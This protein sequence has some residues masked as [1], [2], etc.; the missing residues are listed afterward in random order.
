[1]TENDKKIVKYCL[2][3]IAGLFLVISFF[4]STKIIKPGHE[5]IVLVLGKARESSISEGL[6]FVFPWISSVKV[7][8]TQVKRTEVKGNE[9][10][11]KDLQ[12]VTSAMVVNYHISKEE[13][14]VLYRKI[15]MDFEDV[16]ISPGIQECFKA[17]TAEYTAESLITKRSE[18]SEKIKEL[19][20]GRLLTYGIIVDQVNVTNFEFSAEF[21]RAIEAKVVMEQDSLRAE[22]ELE[23]IKFEAMQKEEEAKGLAAAIL[24]QAKA[25][26]ESLELRAKAATPYVIALDAIQQWDGKLPVTITFLGDKS[27][28][29]PIFNIKE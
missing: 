13:V 6:N 3:F 29:V 11:S 19:L 17:I 5:G 8:S 22:K 14:V 16:V 2:Y 12:V 15:G 10:S 28:L 20:S 9:A 23:K 27:D 25:E 4:M 24:E 18:V 26:A 1:M 21:N 7:M